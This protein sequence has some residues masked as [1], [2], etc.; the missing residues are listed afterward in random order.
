MNDNKGLFIEIFI[1]SWN[2]DHLLQFVWFPMRDIRQF[3][4]FFILLLSVR[5]SRTHLLI[6]EVYRK[7]ACDEGGL[8]AHKCVHRSY[9]SFQLIA[10]N[11]QT[12]RQLIVHS[13]RPTEFLGAHTNYN[14]RRID[15]SDGQINW[16]DLV[17]WNVWAQ[18]T[19]LTFR[20]KNRKLK[21]LRVPTM[22]NICSL[23]I[24]NYFH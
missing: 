8:K 13:I 1:C 16:C 7:A 22:I 24:M 19:F 18:I 20:I 14:L 10:V 5:R 15:S 11:C 4:N 21:N 9:L 23:R 3:L 6:D 12:V 17:R 2:D